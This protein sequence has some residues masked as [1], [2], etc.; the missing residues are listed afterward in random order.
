[1]KRCLSDMFIVT[2]GVIYVMAFL[3]ID[4]SNYKQTWDDPYDSYTISL[5]TGSNA[6]AKPDIQ[7]L[8]AASESTRDFLFTDTPVTL[9]LQ[10]FIR[11]FRLAVCLYLRHAVF[12]I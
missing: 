12:L 4:V 5:K 9:F 6:I 8:S 3:E 1:M 2:V 10:P 7:K 11:K